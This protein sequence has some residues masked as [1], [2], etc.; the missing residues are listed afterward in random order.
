MDRKVTIN[1]NHA[2]KYRKPHRVK[3]KTYFIGIFLRIGI[4]VGCAIACY[5][6]GNRSFLNLAIGGGIGI[7]VVTLELLLGR[8]RLDIL[9]ISVIGG[10]LGF[11]LSKL[12]DYVVYLID[13][14]QLSLFFFRH[15]LV[16]KLCLIYL[17]VMIAL[18]KY[19]ELELVDKE[20]PFRSK[21]ESISDVKL[22]DTSVIIDGRILDICASKFLSGFFILPRFVLNEIHNLADSEE[23]LKRAR[24]KRGL[25]ILNQLRSLGN[26]TVRIF[27]KDYPH[28]RG[29]DNKLI[30]MAKEYRAKLLTTDY[31]LNKIASLQGVTVLNINELSAALKIIYLPGESFRVEVIKEGKEV[32]QGVGY[33]P[34]GTMVVVENGKK[35][36]GKTIDVTVTSTLQTSSGRI[37]FVEPKV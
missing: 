13:Q 30:Q 12:L 1:R 10:I 4:V 31:N 9:I 32:N 7:L 34:D 28:I 6:I 17:G 2:P 37:I 11:I 5:F 35:F 25:D 29:V 14:E 27:D 36:I 20:I 15:S 18:K 16:I 22:L 33:L 3:S 26:I 8:I 19:S 23:H 24:G 21:K